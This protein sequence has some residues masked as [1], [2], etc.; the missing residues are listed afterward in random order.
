MR[1]DYTLLKNRCIEQWR[2]TIFQRDRYT[3]TACGI[4]KKDSPLQV[5]LI[6]DCAVFIVGY[7]ELPLEKA[8]NLSFRNDN[9]T[10]LCSKCNTAYHE[11]GNGIKTLR[12]RRVEK[13]F[14][15]L[16]WERGWSSIAELRS[17]GSD[18][19]S[20]KKNL[21]NRLHAVVEQRGGKI[22]YQQKERKGKLFVEELQ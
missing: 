3:C 15:T 10:T 17:G 22:M 20:S 19:K 13:R 6:T 5:A 4:T 18:Q 16:K 14:N 7:K 9:L 8:V 2:E 21:F 1:H 12:G 11:L